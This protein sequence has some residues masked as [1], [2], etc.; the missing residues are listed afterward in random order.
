MRCRDARA[1]LTEEHSESEAE[2]ARQRSEALA[3]L[4]RCPSCQRYEQQQQRLEQML[5]ESFSPVSCSISTEQ[6]MQAIYLRQR[7]TRQLEELHQQQRTR[8]ARIRTLS[9]LFMTFLFILTAGIPLLLFMLFFNQPELLVKTLIVLSDTVD[10]FLVVLT[11]LRLGL[12]VVSQ[13]NLLLTALA[14][15]LLLL[16]AIWLRLMRVPQEA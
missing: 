1:W 10:V 2:T 14:F 12:S 5:H 15:L 11:Y 4:A 16:A 9:S 3:H 7:T 13:D 6:I 8:L